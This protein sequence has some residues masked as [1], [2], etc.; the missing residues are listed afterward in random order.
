SN[1]ELLEA[2]NKDFI[3][4]GFDL[5]HIMRVIVSSRVYQSS[6]STN[7]WNADDKNNFSHATP[8]RLEAEQLLDAI[9]LATG[10]TSTFKDLPVGTKAAHLPDA[11]ANDADGF[12]DLFGR[13]ARESP[14]ECERSSTVSLGQ[15][16][17]LING[18][19]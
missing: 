18:P 6:I 7:I 1:P 3:R 13:P 10:T 19:T 17:A 14:C 15:A 9:N 8:R 16:M 11:A 5:K 2:L 12:L 4:S